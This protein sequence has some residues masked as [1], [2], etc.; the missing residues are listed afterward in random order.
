MEWIRNVLVKL[1]GKKFVEQG[2]E[3]V[4]VSK[5]KVAAVA[6]ALLLA[7]KAGLEAYNGQPVDWFT[8]VK[9]VLEALGLWAVRDAIK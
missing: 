7:A 2:L 5:A 1:V 6:T 3:K 9:G 8:T 4:G